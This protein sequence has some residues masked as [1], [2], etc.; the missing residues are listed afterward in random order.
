MSA[1]HDD[2]GA[3]AD[4]PL[5]ELDRARI[6]YHGAL[7][8]E[9]NA[10]S[11]GGLVVLLGDFSPLFALLARSAE[12]Y[13]G[14]A[15]VGG[16]SAERAVQ[17]GAVGLARADTR[18]PPE[19][20]PERYL[21]ESA[22]LSGMNAR[23]AARAVDEALTRFE[24]ARESR[25]KLADL[26]VPFRR[27]LSL[28]HATLGAP[29]ALAVD[30]LLGGVDAAAQ[31]YLAAAI[32]RAAAGRP[33][34]A[35]VRGLRSDGPERVLVERASSV[36]VERGGRVS[37]ASAASVLGA[38]TRYS[39]LVTH[40][41]DE[42]A[43]KLSEAGIQSVRTPANVSLLGFTPRDPAALGRFVFELPADKTPADVVR[44][45]HEAGAPLVELI[46]ALE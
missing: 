15:R 28:A 41:G 25:R 27:V 2:E 44:A 40:S 5:I 7:G 14:V 17:S 23:T 11:T 6:R 32:E 19:W 1:R 33:L 37:L 45:A 36:L 24:L 30:D 39:A 42:F 18:L 16:T 31:A 34:L 9:L 4:A 10:R 22:S 43:R 8:A 13:G 20:T 3:P 46:R 35:G 29:H 12:L 38:G 26:A 21:S